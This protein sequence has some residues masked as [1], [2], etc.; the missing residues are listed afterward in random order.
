MVG[1]LVGA[2][3]GSG[4]G[5]RSTHLLTINGE[6][7]PALLAWQQPVGWVGRGKEVAVREGEMCGWQSWVWGGVMGWAIDST[8]HLPLPIVGIDGGD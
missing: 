4:G 2:G 5:G 6:Y 7:P 3:G 8:I 1:W